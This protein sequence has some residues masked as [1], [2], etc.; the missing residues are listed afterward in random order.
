VTQ[1]K[2]VSDGTA[3]T[4]DEEIRAIIDRNYKRA[5]QILQTI[6]T[7]CTPWPTR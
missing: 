1:H 6:S 4:I 7:N 3:H 2:S 5:T